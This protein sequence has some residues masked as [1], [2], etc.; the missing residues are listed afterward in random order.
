MAK[1]ITGYIDHVGNCFGWETILANS[2][3]KILR[4]CNDDVGATQDASGPPGVARH[5]GWHR[6][7]AQ[8]HKYALPKELSETAGDV[9]HDKTC[10]TKNLQALN[11]DFAAPSNERT[12]DVYKSSVTVARM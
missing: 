1:R 8:K 11:V 7:T 3:C 5:E 12:D 6:T 2:S 9:L 10:P 4:R